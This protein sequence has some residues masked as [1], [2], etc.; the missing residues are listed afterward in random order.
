[1]ATAVSL[2]VALFGATGSIGESTLSV[3]EAHPDRF[4]L[5]VVSA[6]HSVDKL[7]DV[8]HRFAPKHVILT[9]SSQADLLL[10]RLPHDFK[11]SVAFGDIALI[12]AAVASEVDVVMAAIVGGAGL[13]STWAAVNA[14]KRICLA[15]KE[16]L[17]MAGALMM[18]DAK[19]TGAMLLPID[20]EH[21]AMFQCL[22]E[23]Y[24]TGE[25]I[26]GLR[27][28]ILTCSGGPF[29]T[30][31]GRKMA[32]AGINDAI[33]HPIW[34]M[35]KKISVDS[36]T[37]MNKGLEL[38]EAT[39]LFQVPES[40]IDVVIHP[41]STVHSMVEFT[42]GS[43]LAQLGS[44]DMRI[45]IAHALGFPNRL[46]IDV[47]RLSLTSLK[48]LHFEAVDHDRF[49][50]LTLARQASD[51]GGDRAIVLN[52]ANEIAVSAFLDGRISFP[53][54]TALVSECLNRLP[55]QPISC[56]EDVLMVDTLCRQA[57]LDWIQEGT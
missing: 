1:M 45:P 28:L 32:K 20:S 33:A 57:A 19:R 23:H 42:D 47:E 7:L 26:E 35:G 56:L 36:A 43:I 22:P 12:E 38:I 51:A 8:I 54:I 13:A 18:A 46:T 50:A 5:E 16:S 3:I 9:D 55:Q 11:G 17:V 29:R 41:E 25:P 39:H 27:Q 15:N 30:W 53:R 52:A 10:S 24:R 44:P 37:L 2:G 4:H 40:A 48:C 14:G 21:N 6:H 31:S 49:P 34:S